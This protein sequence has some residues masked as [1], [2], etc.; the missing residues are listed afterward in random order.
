MGR[1]ESSATCAGSLGR[2]FQVADELAIEHDVG[3]PRVKRRVW[4]L[5]GLERKVAGLERKIGLAVAGRQ[6]E[7]FGCC[8]KAVLAVV[9]LEEDNLARA[10][11]HLK[12]PIGPARGQR[13]FAHDRQALSKIPRIPDHSILPAR[14]APGHLGLDIDRM[15]GLEQR[16]GK[17]D[18]VDRDLIDAR[19][20][21]V[22]ALLQQA[23]DVSDQ[24]FLDVGRVIL[25]GNRRSRESR[26][27]G[28]W[29][30]P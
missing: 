27:P 7:P 11:F 5:L 1:S 28:P 17:L 21:E 3:E 29:D 26:A 30:G 4:L 10:P 9:D 6:G 16:L 8:K 19:L 15:P 23:D 20:G 2:A 25:A 13:I 12:R 18:L 22:R 14:V 24:R